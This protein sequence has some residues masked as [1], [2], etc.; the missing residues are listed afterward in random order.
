M[1][2]FGLKWWMIWL[3]LIGV[4][5]LVFWILWGGNKVEF[6]GLRNLKKEL[7]TSL[8]QEKV[9]VQPPSYPIK[10]EDRSVTAP[11]SFESKGEEILRRTLETYYS[12]PFPKKRPLWLRNPDTGSCLELDCYNEEL[13]IAGEYQGIQHYEYPNVFHRSRE[14]FIAQLRRDEAKI[15]LCDQNGI[16]LIRV[17]HHV[18]MAEIPQFVHTYLPDRLTV[19]QDNLESEGLAWPDH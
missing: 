19:Y 18:P 5:F 17:P 8:G 13:G 6:I 16:Y 14:E 9:F 1:G 15:N 2:L 10:K 7:A 4:L 11:T 12:K 3:I